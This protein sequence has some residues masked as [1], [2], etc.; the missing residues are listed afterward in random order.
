MPLI[1]VDGKINKNIDGRANV[2]KRKYEIG[3]RAMTI[4]L[5][6]EKPN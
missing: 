2:R 5:L 1:S 3:L 4:Q 6:I